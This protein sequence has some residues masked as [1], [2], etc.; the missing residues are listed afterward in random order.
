MKKNKMTKKIMGLMATGVMA[1]SFAVTASAASESLNAGGATWAGGVSSSDNLF[2]R[3]RDNKA[4]GLQ[5]S[6]RVWVV[7]D[8]GTKKEKVGET[9]GTGVDGQV[10]TYVGAT[11]ANPF[12]ANRCGY[13]DFEVLKVK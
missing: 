2:S 7:N 8:K 9:T 4:D 1:L 11:T 6:V 10:K 12:V 13:N 3:L 5:Y